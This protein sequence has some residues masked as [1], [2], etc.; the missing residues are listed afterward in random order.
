[1]VA[2]TPGSIA[3][4]NTSNLLFNPLTNSYVPA[5]AA[6]TEQQTPGAVEAT[7]M[8]VANQTNT[9]DRLHTLGAGRMMTQNEDLMQMILVELRAIKFILI[10]GL[11]TSTDPDQI[12]QDSL[13]YDNTVSN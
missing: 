11:N 8:M 10:E 3:G 4:L 1:M 9:F 2:K 6:T 5:N 7:A 13:V 12:A